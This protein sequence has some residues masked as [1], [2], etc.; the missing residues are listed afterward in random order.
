MAQSAAAAK[1]QAK[2]QKPLPEL[3]EGYKVKDGIAWG[4]RLPGLLE[5]AYFNPQK[6]NSVTGE[7]QMLMGR[8]INAAQDDENIK[9]IFIHGGLFYS[10]GNELGALASGAANFSRDELVDAA[11]LGI[12]HRMVT[13]LMAIQKSRKPIVALIRGVAVGITFTAASLFDFIYCTP[14]AKFATPFMASC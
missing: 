7:G 6:R 9:V 10:A 2:K 1:K 4:S 13:N 5:I 8:L 3:P 12:E 14:E 11:S